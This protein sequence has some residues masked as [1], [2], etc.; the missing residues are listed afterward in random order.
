VARSPAGAG[1][2]RRARPSS[3]W[4][5]RRTAPAYS[6][7][8]SARVIGVELVAH[9]PGGKARKRAQGSHRCGVRPGA[10]GPRRRVSHREPRPG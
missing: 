3:G 2:G 8:S 7:R 10:R 6:E 5:R 1:A 4:R 9:G